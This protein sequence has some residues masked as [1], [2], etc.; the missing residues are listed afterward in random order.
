MAPLMAT[1]IHVELIFTN[2][3]IHL[4]LRAPTTSPLKFLLYRVTVLRSQVNRQIFST[5]RSE[6]GLFPL[7]KDLRNRNRFPTKIA[8]CSC[9]VSYSQKQ[10]AYHHQETC[11][12]RW[13]SLTCVRS[14]CPFQIFQT[15][16]Y[17]FHFLRL[18]C[19]LLG[20]HRQNNS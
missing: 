6:S 13:Q 20:M 17:V 11:T 4:G 12:Q 15:Q 16:I 19:H 10:T 18:P 3:L 7:R 14:I 1:L 2:A 9:C 5:I 8:Q